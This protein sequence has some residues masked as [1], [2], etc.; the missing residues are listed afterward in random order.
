MPINPTTSPQHYSGV[1][2]EPEH[3]IQNWP[4]ERTTKEKGCKKKKK[5]EFYCVE[6]GKDRQ[7]NE[8]IIDPDNGV[9]VCG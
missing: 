2:G 7:H 4:R 8:Q 1:F 5:K 6:S 3:G 9:G